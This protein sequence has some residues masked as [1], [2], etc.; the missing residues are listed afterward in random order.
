[1]KSFNSNH[2]STDVAEQLK[3]PSTCG[4]MRLRNAVL[5]AAFMVVLTGL[6]SADIYGDLTTTLY[7]PSCIMNGECHVDPGSTGSPAS[8]AA[9]FND[10]PPNYPPWSYT[11]QTG[12]AT[13]WSDIGG[14]Y[15]AYFNSGSFDMTGPYGLAF[16]GTISL[17]SAFQGPAGNQ[18][19]D[20]NFSGYWTDGSDQI[21][22]S[23]VAY[24]QEQGANGDAY[25]NTAAQ[26]PEPSSLVMFG[27]GLV[28]LGGLLRR[29]FLS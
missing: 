19:V 21:Y 8:G 1:M 5:V 17:A 15:A 25:L 23:G 10:L 6:A 29:R 18:E 9:N 14:H 26:A 4:R 2:Y 27:S 3:Q 28:G 12:T 22:A 20:V 16:T 24:I 13:S 11:F 7:Y